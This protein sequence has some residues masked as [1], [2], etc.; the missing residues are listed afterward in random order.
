ME[1]VRH[2]KFVW[3]TVAGLC[4][5]GT[6]GHAAEGQGAAMAAIQTLQ[7][8]GGEKDGALPGFI[9]GIVWNDADGN[10]QFGDNE[11]GL[12]GV[13]VY[14]DANNN[15]VRDSGEQTKST[16]RLGIYAF[17]N[18]APG[19]YV[20]RQQV[21]FGWRNVTGGTV[22]DTPAA[23]ATTRVD[24]VTAII[25]GDITTPGE[26][27]F[28]VAVGVLT[29]QGFRQFCGGALLTDRW[30][31][32]AAH[33]SDGLDPAI[34]G[35]LA[36]TN[37]LN[38]GSGQVL[39]VKQIVL[40]P[41][42]VIAPTEPGLPFGVA[43]GFDVALWE[44]DVPVALG[45]KS[46]LQ[47]VGMLSAEND[48]LAD[49]GTLATAIGWGVSDLDSDLLQ[50][51]HL[52]I[53]DEAVCADVY[54]TSINFETQICGGA[55]EGGIDACQGDSGG[56]LLVR[57]F[58]SNQWKL[59]GLTSYGNGCALPGNPGVWAR[60]SVLSEWAEAI[61]VDPSRVHRFSVQPGS[62]KFAAFGNR[63]TRFEPSRPI[64]ARWQLVGLSNTAAPET[65][66]VFDWRILDESES[67]RKFNCEIDIDGPGPAVPDALSCQAGSNRFAIPALED[68]VYIHEVSAQLGDTAFFREESSVVGSPP[69]TNVGGE[70]TAGDALDPDFTSGPFFID[71]FDVDGL[72][73]QKAVQIR[74]ASAEVDVF[75]G[76]YDRQVREANGGGGAI[77]FFFAETGGQPAQ[78]VFFPN[79]DVDYVIG[80]SSFSPE[81]VGTYEV[82]VVNE[83]T[84]VATELVLEPAAESGRALRKLPRT[85]VV[86]SDPAAR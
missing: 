52:P 35:V 31:I 38:D 68:G 43:A 8:G 63:S 75:V 13:T 1:F 39:T 72:T 5:F 11:R 73:A 69:E 49:V 22:P 80:V 42:Y 37:N 79:P 30:V 46:G 47:T 40:H 41:H 10:G 70:L 54:F 56:P 6:T 28:M 15:G 74:V 48:V 55:P 85:R 65:G 12:Q 78:Y 64:D 62:A 61:A 51:V 58:D 84:A 60:V 33:C 7:G 76:L 20:V 53:F 21:P 26:Y 71:Y 77:D 29:D 25:G 19:E 3:G 18:L 17:F 86:T 81:E 83:G 57:D 36:G 2:P 27:P 9:F 59:A 34:A 24:P 66:T 16:N 67:P 45:G 44:L 82:S 50:D 14:L 4:A 32:T 23:T